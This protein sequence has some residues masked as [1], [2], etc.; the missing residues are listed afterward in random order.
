MNLHPLVIFDSAHNEAGVENAM[1]ALREYVCRDLFVVYGCVADK[2]IAPILR[3]LP[4]SATYFFCK[5]DIPRGRDAKDL[6]REA[7]RHGLKGKAYKSV[8][9]AYT[10]ARKAAVK[11]DIVLVA[12]SVFV[13]A[14]L[15]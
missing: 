9:D 5:P 1:K 6:Q 13:V 14:E 7:A 2:D 10:A 11:S 15:L 12:G 4:V 3:Q 8:A